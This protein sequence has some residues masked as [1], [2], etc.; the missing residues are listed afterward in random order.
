MQ[1]T[2]NY[3]A[4]SSYPIDTKV[5]SGNK[6]LYILESLS[7]R[8]KI[9]LV[10]LS[11]LTISVLAI[12]F[13]IFVLFTPADRSVLLSKPHQFNH[14]GSQRLYR[15]FM[16]N[17]IDENTNLIIG[18]HGFGDTSRRF[19]YYTALHNVASDSIVLYPQA[20]KPTQKGTKTGWNAV[21]CCGSGWYSKTDD[22]DFISKLAEKFISEY[23]LKPE[24]VFV[25]GF[26]NGAFMAQ[27]LIVDR[28]DIFRAAA[29][30]SGSIGTKKERLFPKT[31]VPIFL[32]H[33]ESD[34]TVPFFGGVGSS[35]PDFSW[36]DFE[37]T[38]EFWKKNNGQA[39]PVNVETY[40]NLKHH[41]NDWRLLNVWHRKPQ[42]SVKVIDFFSNLAS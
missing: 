12:V 27:R 26:S 34:T 39:A 29:V 19:A 2:V 15:V 8:K 1:Y 6:Y 41:W 5:L 21:F 16:P 23:E 37:T 11:L 22:V 7:V 9:M 24:N 40:P 35:D 31:P 28:P 13:V 33:G 42:A 14:Q 25:T 20:V 18:L 4:I 36:L 38:K 17:Q 30:V 32:M 3:T 10:L